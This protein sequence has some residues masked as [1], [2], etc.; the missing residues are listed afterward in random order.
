MKPSTARQSLLLAE[1]LAAL[2]ALALLGLAAALYPLSPVGAARDPAQAAAPW[3]FIGVQELLRYLP[4]IIGG[5]VLPAAAWLL[6][7]SMPWLCQGP[8]PVLPTFRRAMPAA[9]WLAL[10]VLAAW[11]ALTIMGLLRA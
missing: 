10:L 4:P 5:L 3:I 6:L 2:A 8:G 9:G 11:A 7:G 1:G